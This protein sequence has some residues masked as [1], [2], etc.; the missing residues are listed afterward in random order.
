MYHSNV[1]AVSRGEGGERRGGKGKEV[2]GKGD[3]QVGSRGCWANERQSNIYIYIFVDLR[4]DTYFV[5]T[6]YIYHDGVS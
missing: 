1:R 3:R 5:H 2:G 6:P 4:Y